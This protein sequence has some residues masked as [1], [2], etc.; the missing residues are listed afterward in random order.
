MTPASI[1][2]HYFA[3]D[4]GTRLAWHEVGE[5]RAVVLIHGYLSDAR[6][7]WIRF[8]HAAAIAARGFRVVMPDLRAH[9]SSDKPHDPARYP[10]DVLA[11]DGH[12]LMRHLGLTDYDL[13]GYSLGARTVCRMLATGAAPRRV[14][15]SGMGLDGLTDVARRAGHFRHVLTNLGRH[16]RGSPAWMTEAFLKT[17][18]GDPVA[19][20]AILDTFVATPRAVIEAFDE[21]AL[22]VNGATDHDNGSAAALADALPHARY[23]EVPGNHMSAVTRPELGEAIADFLAG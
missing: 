1:E 10:P 16:E 3:A 6:T 18:G 8:G 12:A 7:N 4:D 17:T 9:G 11:G 13:G 23:T 2:P 21:P 20:L 14:V 5:G 19:L 15:F 22:V